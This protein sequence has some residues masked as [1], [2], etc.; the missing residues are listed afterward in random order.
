M[1]TGHD[2][3]DDPTLLCA[4]VQGPL[5]SEVPAQEGG[6]LL[7]EE[8]C[9]DQVDE[10]PK[11]PHRCFRVKGND[12]YFTCQYS[13]ATEWTT[14]D[15]VRVSGH[16]WTCP[17]SGVARGVRVLARKVTGSSLAALLPGTPFLTAQGR[18]GGVTCT[19]NTYIRRDGR[20]C[21]PS[22][23]RDQPHTEHLI[24]RASVRLL[25]PALKAR[26]VSM[27]GA[28]FR[29]LRSPPRVLPVPCVRAKQRQSVYPR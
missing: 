29:L 18:T 14:A 6:K 13:G 7:G 11:T 21:A 23:G 22:C 26:I 1:S 3:S 5:P 24:D 9:K 20:R 2:Q 16:G 27:Y 8:W 15:G 17:H 25:L 4:D 28:A 10:H 19:S 12:G